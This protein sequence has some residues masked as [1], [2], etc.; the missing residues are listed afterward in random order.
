MAVERVTGGYAGC[1]NLIEAL[2]CRNARGIYRLARVD[3]EVSALNTSPIVW[4]KLNGKVREGNDEQLE[5]EVRRN[6]E[7]SYEDLR[8]PA[9]LAVRLDV[10]AI[11]EVRRLRVP[12]LREGRGIRCARRTLVSFANGQSGW[13]A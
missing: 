12:V 11:L 2:K 8:I 1:Q 7:Q 10:P 3:G 5:L 13:T 4:A 6:L 9:S